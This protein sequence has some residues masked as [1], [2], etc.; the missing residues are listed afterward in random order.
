MNI[1]TL[2]RP[3]NTDVV[4][5]INAL[6]TL[7]CT[8]KNKTVYLCGDFN[9]NILNSDRDTNT[10]NFLD[11]LYSYGLHP[12]VTKP[13]RI[14]EYSK[15]IIDNIFT[16]ETDIAINSGLLICDITDHLPVFAIP[17]YSSLL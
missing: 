13:T 10:G 1:C 2:Y 12:L 15:T 16:T 3:P 7:L 9:I 5:F 8:L 11:M 17:E 4:N 6:E 14:T